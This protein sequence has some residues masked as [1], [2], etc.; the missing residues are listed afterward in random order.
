VFDEQDPPAPKRRGRRVEQTPVQRA[1]GLLVRREHSRSEL[2]RKL[3]ARGIER[4][5]AQAAVDKLSQ[6]GWQDEERFA[7]GLVRSR[8]AAG[9]GPL[10][11]RA[12]LGMHRL[13]DELIRLAMDE[14]DGDWAQNARDLVKRRFG[15]QLDDPAKRRKAAD[16]L[17]RRG[18]GGALVSQVLRG[19]EQDWDDQA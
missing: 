19:G 4:D 9:Y 18:F 10:H 6:A 12:E 15:G 1:L 8:A 13:S 3:T 2:T 17:A 16:L 14:F 7:H 5:E 11:I